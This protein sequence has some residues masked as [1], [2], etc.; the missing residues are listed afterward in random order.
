MDQQ[1]LETFSVHWTA[2]FLED[3]AKGHTD[4]DGL[5]LGFGQTISQP[6]V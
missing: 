3:D 5:C 4:L 6:C 2:R 1:E